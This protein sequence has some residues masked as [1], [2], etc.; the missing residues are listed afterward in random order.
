VRNLTSDLYSNSLMELFSTSDGLCP[1]DI[2]LIT[3]DLQGVETSFDGS[4]NVVF[5]NSPA[6]QDDYEILV[7]TTFSWDRVFYVKV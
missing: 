2:S 3:K 6:N 1:F 4:P 5:D 7:N